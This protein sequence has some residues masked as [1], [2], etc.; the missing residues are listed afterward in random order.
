MGA[1]KLPNFQNYQRVSI[2]TVERYE[3]AWNWLMHNGENSAK[4]KRLASPKEAHEMPTG[5]QAGTHKHAGKHTQIH[6]VTTTAT[7]IH[8]AQETTRRFVNFW[9]ADS[10]KIQRCSVQIQLKIQIQPQIHKQSALSA[11]AVVSCDCLLSY[12]IP[13]FN[14]PN[15]YKHLSNMYLMICT[16]LYL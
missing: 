4:L 8:A 10:Q 7:F 5:R 16:Y 15:L 6:I 12:V 14:C 9:I 2:E 1:L 11:A 3:S 13:R